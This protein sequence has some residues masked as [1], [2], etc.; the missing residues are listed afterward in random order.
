MF[1]FC[2]QE[3]FSKK[4]N[5]GG[6]GEGGE[7]K[8]RIHVRSKDPSRIARQLEKSLA[9]GGS[10]Q[11]SSKTKGVRGRGGGAKLIDPL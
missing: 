11:K 1:L 2:P 6:G 5:G 10:K 7:V 3:A 4:E 9:S 8:K